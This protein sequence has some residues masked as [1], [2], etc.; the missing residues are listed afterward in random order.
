MN[1]LRIFEKSM[2][3]IE[4]L[5][6][7]PSS[8]AFKPKLKLNI[9]MQKWSSYS[10]KIWFYVW[11]WVRCKSF[12]RILIGFWTRFGCSISFTRLPVGG[13][14]TRMEL[15][16]VA[17][18]FEHNFRTFQCIHCRYSIGHVIQYFH[19]VWNFIR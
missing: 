7:K 9:R 12:P 13:T 16:F 4:T 2:I 11:L 18:L 1:L 5:I 15:Q 10:L 8:F 17:H 19:Y 3:Q 6:E 14:R